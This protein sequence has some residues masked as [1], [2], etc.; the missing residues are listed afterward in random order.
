[1]GVGC[2]VPAQFRNVAYSM[3]LE[4][5]YVF[6][7]LIWNDQWAVWHRVTGLVEYVAD[8]RLYRPDQHDIF[9]KGAAER[10]CA[11]LNGT[12]LYPDAETLAEIDNTE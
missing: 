10:E 2:T 4:Y 12:S 11:R 1:M 9:N 3:G 8:E 7:K 5:P 6:G